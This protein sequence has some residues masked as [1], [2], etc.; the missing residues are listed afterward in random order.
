M[1]FLISPNHHVTQTPGLGQSRSADTNI[2]LVL[3]ACFVVKNPMCEIV[4]EM[5][6]LLLATRAATMKNT[7]HSVRDI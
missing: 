4:G 2:F 3:E 5:F 7:K 6:L 1:K